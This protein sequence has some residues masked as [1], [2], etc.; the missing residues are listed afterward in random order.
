M[1]SVDSPVRTLV[2]PLLFRMLR[3][4][5][6]FWILVY[7]KWRD[8]RHHLVEEEEE[9]LLPGFVK[10]GDETVDVGA[11]FLYYAARMSELAGPRG[12]VYAFEPVPF[13]FSIAKVLRRMLRLGNVEL[14]DKGVSDRNERVSFRVPLQDFGAPSAGLSHIASR[15]NELDGR[16]TFYQFHKE[17]TVACEV[18]RIDDFLLP[19]LTRLSF[20]KIDIEGAE[21][22]ALRGMRRTIAQF[23]PVILVEIQP[24]FL[25]GF[26]IT[27]D[28]VARLIDE[29]GYRMF[30]YDAAGTR[31]KPFTPPF[32]PRNY[33][34]VHRERLNEYAS[35]ID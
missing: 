16:E 11:N 26:G 4:E 1:A 15:N 20:V 21:Y 5:W 34:L 13:T 12:T 10:A 24:F 3:K 23:R 19:R 22:F 27:E 18:V 7:A 17:Y 6:Y 2:K 14:I 32:D 9:S 28:D 35:L 33:I 30:V 29:M 8:I 31:L 25:N